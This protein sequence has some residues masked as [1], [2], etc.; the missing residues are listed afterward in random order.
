[1]KISH[2]E[3]VVY[4]HINHEYIS[5]PNIMIYCHLITTIVNQFQNILVFQYLRRELYTTVNLQVVFHQIA[6]Y[7][8]FKLRVQIKS[9]ITLK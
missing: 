3:L 7:K 5:V 2:L 4:H 8:M 9:F 6:H 1:M